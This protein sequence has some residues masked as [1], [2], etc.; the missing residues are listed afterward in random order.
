MKK[1][2]KIVLSMFII[3]SLNVMT[4]CNKKEEAQ[5]EES[6]A[7]DSAD[8]DEEIVVNGKKGRFGDYINDNSE[9]PA[10]EE[11]SE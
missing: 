3:L 2:T 8:L 4:G 7:L 6:V 5:I 10:E 11:E 9:Q 1:L